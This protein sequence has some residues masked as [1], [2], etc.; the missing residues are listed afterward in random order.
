MNRIDKLL[1]L[2][3]A[4]ARGGME[5]SHALITG[6]G[7]SWTAEAF[8][9]DGVPGHAPTTKRA[10]YATEGAAVEY[11]RAV[12]KEYP[13]SKDVPIIVDDV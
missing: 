10:T 1:I 2:A 13:N 3:K 9:S 8:L 11:I 4:A 12:A 5:L 6:S 7:H